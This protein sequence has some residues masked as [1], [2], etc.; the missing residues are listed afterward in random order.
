MPSLWSMFTG[1]AAKNELGKAQQ[2]ASAYMGNA[3]NQA[4]GALTDSWNTAQGYVNPLIQSGNRGN[5]LY[6]NHLGVNGAEAQQNAMGSFQTSPGYQYMLQ[7]RMKGLNARANAG[8]GYYSG[9]ALQAAGDAHQGMMSQEYG[10]YLNR[11]GGYAQQ[12]QQAAMQG[13]GLAS[14]YGSQMAGLHQGYGSAMAG[15]AI[16][17]GNAMAQASNAPLQNILGLA[18]LGIGGLNAYNAYSRLPR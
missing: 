1:S 11:L 6:A 5:D 16:N 2:Q 10:N 4:Q 9:A 3:Y 14:N 12:G 18:G 17:Y 13:A 8:G 15:N 7:Q